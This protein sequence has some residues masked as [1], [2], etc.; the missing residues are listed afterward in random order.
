[1]SE[2][3]HCGKPL[4]YVSKA[5]ED[6]ISKIIEAKGSRFVNI[7]QIETGRTFKVDSHYVALHGVQGNLLH[8]Y[9]FEEIK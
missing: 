8:T 7:T 5:V 3:C 4:H 9:G 2:L 1:M 6:A